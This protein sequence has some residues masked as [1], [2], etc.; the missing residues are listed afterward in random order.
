MKCG[1]NGEKKEN[2]IG[3]LDVERTQ[4]LILPKDPGLA[5]PRQRC[6]QSI[7][8]VGYLGVAINELHTFVRVSAQS[9]CRMTAGRFPEA[10]RFPKTASKFLQGTAGLVQRELM[11]LGEYRQPSTMYKSCSA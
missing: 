2:Q 6:T 11:I 4:S 3:C 7:T 5:S 10:A 1:E 8:F 9:C